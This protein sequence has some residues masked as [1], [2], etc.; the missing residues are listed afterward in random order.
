VAI[1]LVKRTDAI[2]GFVVL[3]AERAFVTHRHLVCDCQTLP[4]TRRSHHPDGRY[5]APQ[6]PLRHRRDDALA[7]PPWA[8][9]RT[10]E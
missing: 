2:N 10:K 9:Y 7:R 3:P 5:R 1:Q 4:E 6:P 8:R